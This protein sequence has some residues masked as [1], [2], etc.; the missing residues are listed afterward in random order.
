MPLVIAPGPLADSFASVAQADTFHESRGNDDWTALTETRKEQLL[1]QGTDYMTG[2][3]RRRWID[4]VGD[5]ETDPV[6]PALANA[7]AILALRASAAPLAPD[8]DTPVTSEQVDAIRVTYAEGARQ[9]V[10]F[11]EVDNMLAAYLL[12]YSISIQLVR[13]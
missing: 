1:R 2:T 13:V 6:P 11:T 12:G 3:Y 10:Q 9:T 4:G 5:L 8:L 7:C